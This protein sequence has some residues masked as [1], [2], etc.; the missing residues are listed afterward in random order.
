MFEANV[1]A[2][3]VEAIS[4]LVVG[5]APHPLQVGRMLYYAQGLWLTYHRVPLFEGE[6]SAATHGPLLAEVP[7]VHREIMCGAHAHEA[8]TTSLPKEIRDLLKEVID[9]FGVYTPAQ[10]SHAIKSER[11][12]QRARNGLPWH[13]DSCPR[14]ETIDIHDFFAE[15]IEWG[16][17]VME[18]VGLPF[19]GDRPSW[20]TPYRVACNVK[21]MA[22]H[23]MFEE[24]YARKL[25]TELG[26]DPVPGDWSFLEP[27]PSGSDHHGEPI[28][29]R[30]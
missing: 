12:W 4:R 22:E 17:D 25:R 27:S 18:S 5:Q 15:M 16:E 28:R 2:H 6:F 10:L 30:A 21:Y 14:I 23:P 26:F 11:P 20:F 8:G 1:L 7:M 24:S 19:E 9:T 29:K 3:E 13:D